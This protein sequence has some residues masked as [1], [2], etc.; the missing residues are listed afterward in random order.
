[1]DEAYW[2]DRCL[3]A[4]LWTLDFRWLAMRCVSA[5]VRPQIG[6]Q[7]QHR[8]ALVAQ[9]HMVL[10]AMED[11]GLVEREKGRA[12]RRGSPAG[13]RLGYLVHVETPE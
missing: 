11:L 4:D 3:A 9:T 13:W 12:G 7:L 8:L 6:Q 10:R 5:L 1:M 2:K